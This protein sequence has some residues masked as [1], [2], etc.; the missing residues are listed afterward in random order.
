MSAEKR[1]S[2]L[3]ISL[4]E[5]PKA[6]GN[7]MTGLRVGDFFH[8]SGH[9]PPPGGGARTTG[10]V[11]KDLSADEG[12]Q[13]ARSTGL[14]ILATVR[15]ALGSL[16]RVQRVV[17]IVGLVNATSDFT[18]HPRVL[19]GVSDLFVE[20]FGEAGRAV[21][22]AVGAASLPRDAAVEVE[23]IFLLVPDSLR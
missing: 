17:K 15:A 9:L 5:A 22:S 3:S 1:L 14:S 20:V 10:K 11:G 23:A 4:P 8:V 6:V 19:N 21:R 2:D 7:Y 18:E 13:A 16:D 12:Y